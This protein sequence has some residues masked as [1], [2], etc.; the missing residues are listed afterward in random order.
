[1]APLMVL[2]VELDLPEDADGADALAATARR[3]TADLPLPPRR[4]WAG[5]RETA[6]AVAELHGGPPT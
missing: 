5:V 1:V 2:V 6:Q 3:V 4:V